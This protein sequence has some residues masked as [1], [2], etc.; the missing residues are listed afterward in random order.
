[1]ADAREDVTQVLAQMREGDKRAADKLLPLVPVHGRKVIDRWL[2]LAAAG[3][4]AALVDELLATHYDPTYGRSM[5]RN[6]PRHTEALSVTPRAIDIAAFRAL[7]R[8]LLVH[9]GATSAVAA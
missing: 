2:A 7:A 6:F 4:F 5:L 1:M 3:D 8:E 9:V